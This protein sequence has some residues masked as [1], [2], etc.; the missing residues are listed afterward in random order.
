MEQG[1]LYCFI[2]GLQS[3]IKPWFHET[4]IKFHAR[5]GVYDHE[6]SLCCYVVLQTGKLICWP[7]FADMRSD[8][9]SIFKLTPHDKQVMMFSATLSSEIRPVCK[10]FMSDVRHLLTAGPSLI[11]LTAADTLPLLP[12]TTHAVHPGR[13]V[14]V[15][16]WRTMQSHPREMP[17]EIRIMNQIAC[18]WSCLDWLVS[19]TCKRW[20]A[21]DP[22]G[23][24]EEVS[25]Q[26]GSSVIIH[27]AAAYS[28]FSISP[29]LQISDV[30]VVSPRILFSSLTFHISAIDVSRV[31]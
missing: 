14:M 26:N 21:A 20:R 24:M 4:P 30:S 29:A 7:F 5:A 17:P 1:K 22:G 3:T 10:K 11:S 6:A 13:L 23:A 25:L 28:L 12:L 31:Q 19:E 9:Q 15:S 27:K 8:I 16:A 18:L 2:G